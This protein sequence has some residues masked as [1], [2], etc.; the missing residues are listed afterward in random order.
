MSVAFVNGEDYVLIHKKI[1]M[2]LKDLY[3]LGLQN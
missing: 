3:L 2:F 1:T